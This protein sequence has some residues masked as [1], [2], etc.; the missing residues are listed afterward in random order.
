MRAF[1]WL[2]TFSLPWAESMGYKQTYTKHSLHFTPVD[3]VHHGRIEISQ[4]A[5]KAAEFTL[6]CCNHGWWTC[7]HRGSF[8]AATGIIGVNK[9]FSKAGIGKKYPSNIW[10]TYL[11]KRSRLFL[12]AQCSKP[13]LFLSAPDLLFS[14]LYFPLQMAVILWTRLSEGQSIRFCKYRA[15]SST[16]WSQLWSFLC[17]WD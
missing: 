16:R 9:T 3:S 14:L 6:F 2:Y 1:C 5:K 8:L 7:Q 11:F 12:S 15:L 13:L 10:W 17:L 4:W